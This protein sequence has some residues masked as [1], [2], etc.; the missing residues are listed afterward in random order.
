M[1]PPETSDAPTPDPIRAT[2]A[3]PVPR[4]APNH[5]SAWPA[6][7]A[8]FSSHKGMPVW[9]R[10]S[11]SSGAA[12]Q[13]WDWLCTSASGPCSTMPGTPM[14]APITD[15][16]STSASAST[17]RRPSAMART[18]TSTSRWRGSSGWSA[19]ARSTSV[20]SYSPVRT[21]VSPMS[22]PMT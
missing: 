16:G 3:L 20:R 5:S 8:R 1:V 10:S 17:A 9:A 6:V 15:A 11:R 7:F 18:T 13:P 14:P 19:L 2:T 4:P 12:S 22:T 21:R